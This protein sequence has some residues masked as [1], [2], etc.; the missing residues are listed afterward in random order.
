MPSILRDAMH[1]HLHDSAVSR[2]QDVCNFTIGRSIDFG[3]Q[4]PENGDDFGFGIVRTGLGVEGAADVPGDIVGK[5]F[6]PRHGIGGLP[7]GEFRA[8]ELFGNH[9]VV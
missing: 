4:F 5:L 2:W 1:K 9:C 6:E 8:D 3:H 7:G